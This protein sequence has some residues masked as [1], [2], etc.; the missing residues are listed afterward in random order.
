MN[1]ILE[2]EETEEEGDNTVKF[3][4]LTYTFKAEEEAPDNT[5]EG[6]H[7]HDHEH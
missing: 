2:V 1:H 5:T 3:K 4:R 6:D 7:D